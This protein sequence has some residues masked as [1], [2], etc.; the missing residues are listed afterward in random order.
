MDQAPRGDGFVWLPDDM[1]P[2]CTHPSSNGRLKI[3]NLLLEFFQSDT[4]T[5]SWFLGDPGLTPTPQPTVTA[6]VTP[7]PFPNL[8]PQ[9][10]LPVVPD[11][12]QYMS[13]PAQPGPIASSNWVT[14]ASVIKDLQITGASTLLLILLGLG[15]S[16]WWGQRR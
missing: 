16:V 11:N 14:E 6:T 2:D 13:S 4:S 7:T 5:T 9:A 1:A 10:Y 3:A 15:F 8:T 12:Y